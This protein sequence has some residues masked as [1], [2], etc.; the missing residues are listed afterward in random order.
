MDPNLKLSKSIGK[1]LNEEEAANYRRL[2][3]RLLYLQISGPDI[4]FVVHRL[5]QYLQKPTSTHLQSVT[6]FF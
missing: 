3:G 2:I 1:P 5:S 4:S 6:S